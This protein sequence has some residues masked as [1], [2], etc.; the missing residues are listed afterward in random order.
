[1]AIQKKQGEPQQTVGKAFIQQWIFSPAEQ[2]ELE[3]V[4]LEY[5]EIDPL[6]FIDKYNVQITGV[7]K[8]KTQPDAFFG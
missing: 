6:Y 8:A 1:M 7:R 4:L 3:R 2:R 5:Y